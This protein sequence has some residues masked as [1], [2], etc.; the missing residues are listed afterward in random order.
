MTSSREI[1][2]AAGIHIILCRDKKSCMK[3]KK[4]ILTDRI[5]KISFYAIVIQ[6]VYAFCKGLINTQD[7]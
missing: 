1:G 4:D 3:I 2:A 6:M 5:L 7:I